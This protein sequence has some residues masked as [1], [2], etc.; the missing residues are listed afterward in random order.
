MIIGR[1]LLKISHSAY[2]PMVKIIHK[3]ARGSHNDLK[4]K[5][6]TIKSAFIYWWK[7]GGIF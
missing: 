2:V 4:S 6:I 7:W 5:W 3:W 1:R